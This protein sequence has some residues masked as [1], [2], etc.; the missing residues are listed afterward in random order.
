MGESLDPDGM[1]VLM[2]YEGETPF[3]YFFKDGLEEEKVVSQRWR[4]AR[5]QFVYAKLSHCLPST[6]KLVP[7]HLA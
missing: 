4:V 1:N 6:L 5:R 3:L 2:I 7:Y